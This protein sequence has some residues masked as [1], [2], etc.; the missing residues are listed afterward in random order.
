MTKL[1]IVVRDAAEAEVAA[2]G[3]A[4]IILLGGSSADSSEAPSPETI[5]SVLATLAGCLPLFVRGSAPLGSDD[6]IAEER[7]LLATGAEWVG[8][9]VAADASFPPALREGTAQSSVIPIPNIETGFGAAVL[10]HFAQAGFPAVLLDPPGEGRGRLLSTLEVAALEAIVKEGQRLGIG[11]W[12]SGGLESPDVTRLLPLR[13]DVLVFDAAVRSGHLR[14]GGLDPSA[15]Q[16]VRAAFPLIGR[17]PPAWSVSAASNKET[18][19]GPIMRDKVYIRDFL[20][21]VRIGV[22]EHEKAA[23]QTVRF[24]VEVVVAPPAADLDGM[25]RI[26]SYDLITDSIRS[27][28]AGGH[29]DFVETLAERIAERILAHPRAERIRIRVEKLEIGPGAV[30]VEIVRER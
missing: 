1:G 10:P 30:G 20:L 27:I 14:S 22:Y 18:V 5:R 13:P 7:E 11:V 29:L 6:A 25:R 15:L 21:P 4:D 17:E 28:V 19:R 2:T 26:F 24:E 12:L 8:L 9:P 23:A 16:S 3:G